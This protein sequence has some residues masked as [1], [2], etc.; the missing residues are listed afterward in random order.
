MDARLVS[1]AFFHSG[2]IKQTLEGKKK[3]LSFHF[4]DAEQRPVKSKSLPRTLSF[5]VGLRLFSHVCSLSPDISRV[6][7]WQRPR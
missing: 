6:D 1:Q 5:L 7:W 3:N 4:P 2:N